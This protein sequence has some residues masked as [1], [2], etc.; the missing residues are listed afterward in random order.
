[1]T[2]KR[3]TDSEKLDKMERLQ[4]KK[5]ASLDEGAAIYSLGKHT[6]R[7]LAKDAD[8]IYRI[9]RRILVNLDKIDEHLELF[10]EES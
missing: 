4:I 7:E 6:F 1:M 9:K 5:F 3:E 2:K 8:A 10:K